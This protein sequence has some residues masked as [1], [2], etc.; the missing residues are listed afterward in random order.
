MKDTPIET[1]DE[2]GV[3]GTL[4]SKLLCRATYAS[5]E[6][7]QSWYGTAPV[8]WLSFNILKERSS[9]PG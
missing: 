4:V 1:L 6:L 8:N 2:T 3:D 5:V 9:R 7:F